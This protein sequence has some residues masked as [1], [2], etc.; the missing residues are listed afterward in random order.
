MGVNNF[1]VMS[2]GR[3]NLIDP[4]KVG[5]E[6]AMVILH[7]T[8]HRARKDFV[9]IGFYIKHIRDNGLYM[10]AGYRN[11]NEF[12]F[13]NFHLSQSSTSRYINICEQFSVDG[14]LCR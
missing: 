6:D 3:V 13:D 7:D 4:H 12:A 1:S 8:F 2:L 9:K 11:I 10:E 14:P 5:Y